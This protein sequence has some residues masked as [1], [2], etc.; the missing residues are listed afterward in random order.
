ML[1]A[2][3]GKTGLLT[4]KLANARIPLHIRRPGAL[5]FH[6]HPPLPQPL[7]PALHTH[8]TRHRQIDTGSTFFCRHDLTAGH[9]P[10]DQKRLGL[11][12]HIVRQ[13]SIRRFVRQILGAGEE[14]QEWP[15]LLRDMITDRSPQH[16]VGG[17][18][19]VQ[20]RAL[21]NRSLN[22]HPHL[23]VDLGQRS[24]MCRQRNSNHD[25]VCTSTDKTAGRSRT[26]GAQLSPSS[27][28][29]YTWPPVVPKYTPHV[30]SESTAIASRST[31]T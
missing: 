28:D 3:L 13:R 23:A 6:R 18:E 31:F 1:Y 25:K 2:R 20:D 22:L 16:R 9:G 24:K 17:L 15:A 5:Q 10:D 21:R 11:T 30:S 27:D 29:A 12:H 19:C 14:S 8:R 7:N 4:S 26:I